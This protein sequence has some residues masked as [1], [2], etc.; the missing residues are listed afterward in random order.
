MMLKR[1]FDLLVSG[2][3]L[4]LLAPILLAIGLAIKLDSQGPAFFRQERVGRFGRT[5]R[6]R[7]FRSMMVDAPV[8]GPQLTV[9]DD[10]RVTRIGGFLRRHKLD[11]LPQLI[12]VFVGNMSI[13]GPRPE[14]P[15]YVA[16]Y[17]PEDRDLVLSVRPG[18]TDRASIEFKGESEIL[19]EALDPE[20][21]YH[22][23]ILPRKLAYYRAYVQRRTFGDDIAIIAATLKALLRRDR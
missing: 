19:G 6:I 20:A 12:D 4:V 10:A 21:T 8:L 22:T 16:L 23:N 11:E 5:F 9:G 18:I 13:V 1:V 2:I 15:R 3:G 14:V 7:K 17:S